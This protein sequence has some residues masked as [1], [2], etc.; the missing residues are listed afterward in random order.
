MLNISELLDPTPVPLWRL[1]KQAGVDQVVSLLDGGEQQWRWPKR[2][3]QYFVP[4]PYVALPAGERPWERPA[5][6]RM[7]EQ[8]RDYGLDVV[9]IEDTAPMD[10][11]RLGG[12]G[13]EEQ[14]D[15]FCTQL[16]AMGELGITTLCYNWVAVTNWARTTRSVP[17]R[18]GAVSTGYDD[19]IMRRAPPLIE[20]GSVTHQQL[21]DAYEYFLRAVVPV[22]EEAGVRIALH[23]D[24]PPLTEVRGVPRIM[25]SPEAFE[26]VLSTVDSEY[27]GITFCQ[28][29][30]SLMTDDVP[31]LIRQLGRDKRIFFA[32][33]RDVVGDAHNF[34]E[35]FHDEGPTDMLECMRAYHDIGFDG[36][37]RPDHVPAMEGE[38]NETFGYAVLGRLFAIGYMTGLREAANQYN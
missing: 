17:L 11:V 31:A 4:P 36:A 10:E 3:S 15:W 33:F 16:R 29:N 6:A 8:Y 24:D 25:G 35:V 12:P 30:F 23:P 18:G 14:I 20:P 22:A 32:H 27:S 19:E 21:W 28:G 1:V 13:R 9:V 34:V 38:S 37:L 26:R 2:E 5:L 7:Q